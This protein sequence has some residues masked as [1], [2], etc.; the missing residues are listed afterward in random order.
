MSFTEFTENQM[1]I[2]I[3]FETEL[4]CVES[5]SRIDGENGSLALIRV[6][7]AAAAHRVAARSRTVD[8]TARRPSAA[9]ASSLTKPQAVAPRTLARSMTVSVRHSG[10][11]RKCC[12]FEIRAFIKVELYDPRYIWQLEG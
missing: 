4:A 6:S 3:F 8:N 1:A 7:S 2:T 10:D 5:I 11:R 12:L 9:S